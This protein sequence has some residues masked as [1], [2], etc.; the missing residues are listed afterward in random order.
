[1]QNDDSVL[2]ID[3]RTWRET[4]RLPPRATGPGHLQQLAL[5]PDG[6]LLFAFTSTATTSAEW[7]TVPAPPPPQNSTT[8]P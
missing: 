1:M 8:P 4:V 5:S 2:L 3:T 6:A 7:R